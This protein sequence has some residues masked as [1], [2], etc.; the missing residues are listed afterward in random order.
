[1]IVVPPSAS[2]ARC[3]PRVG[4]P[5]AGHTVWLSMRSIRLLLLAV[6][7]ACSL[8]GPLAPDERRDLDRARDRWV[9]KGLKEYTFETRTFCFCDPAISSW[10][11]V[12]VRNDTVVSAISLNALPAGITAAPLV[13]WRSV[14]GLFDVIVSSAS[15][16][17]ARDIKVTY[18]DELG[19]PRLIDVRCQDNIADC[20]VTY[21]ARNLRAIR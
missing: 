7:S 10:T 18:D 13:A 21:E 17:F 19:Y 8:D 14:S 15:S 12:H 4:D 6:L 1:M 2:G 3:V 9:A 5:A 16:S 20:G 11:E